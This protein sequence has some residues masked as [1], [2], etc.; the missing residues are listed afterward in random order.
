VPSVWIILESYTAEKMATVFDEFALP[1]CER[2]FVDATRIVFV[3]TDTKN[4]YQRFHSQHNFCV[5]NN[6]LNPAAIDQYMARVSKEE[7]R[8][9]IGAPPGQ[10]I[11]TMVGTICA[12]KDQGTLVEAAR[13]LQAERRDFCC[14]LVGLRED[15][16]YSRQLKQALRQ[17]DLNEVVK[18]IPE[19]SEVYRYFRAADIF[20]FTSRV[21]GYSL[22]I[23]EAEAFGLPLVCTPCGGVSEQMF[24][25]RNGFLFEMGH[26]PWLADRLRT[27]LDDHALRAK[28]GKCSRQ[29]FNFLPS[30]PE[31]LERY[32]REFSGLALRGRA[33]ARDAKPS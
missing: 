6:G 12:R 19:T 26:A 17:A 7:A 28:M 16:P 27:L 5:V 21:E 11:I 3:S 32:E 8:A 14:Y 13:L 31:M 23:L 1:R 2:A 15:D 33:D 24:D 10:K 29:V 22:A 25:G 30:Y 4:L 18:L 9:E 20:A